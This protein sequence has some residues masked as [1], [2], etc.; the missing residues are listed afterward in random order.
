MRTDSDLSRPRAAADVSPGAFRKFSSSS[1]QKGSPVGSSEQQSRPTSSRNN[2]TP[3]NMKTF[4]S[5]L[6][7]IE[8]LHFNGSSSNERVKY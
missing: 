1:A 2:N 6:R 8:G 5:T 4:E 7:G 3:S